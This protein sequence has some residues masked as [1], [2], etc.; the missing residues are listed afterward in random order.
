[1]SRGG[2]KCFQVYQS[3]KVHHNGLRVLTVRQHFKGVVDSVNGFAVK[4]INKS[5]LSC[6]LVSVLKL[7]ECWLYLPSS[8]SQYLLMDLADSICIMK[9]LNLAAVRNVLLL[10]SSDAAS[11]LSSSSFL[12]PSVSQATCWTV[13]Y[14]KRQKRT[15][16]KV[17]KR[18]VEAQ[19]LLPPPKDYCGVT[20]TTNAPRTQS[21]TRAG[22]E[23]GSNTNIWV[24]F[25]EKLVFFQKIQSKPE[26][27]KC[28]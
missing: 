20:A 18:P 25:P 13:C 6:L 2:R 10:S 8:C 14:W 4:P 27:G 23:A 11:S 9:H 17:G 1:M 26:S 21:T 28:W 16:W 22:K 19:S 7:V 3:E 15:Q 12:F 24:L 5:E